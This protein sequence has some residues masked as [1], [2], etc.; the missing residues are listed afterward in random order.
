MPPSIF[1]ASE[2]E[3]TYKVQLAPTFQSQRGGKLP[4]LWLTDTADPC[5]GAAAGGHH[6][7]HSA[8]VRLM[9]RQDLAAEAYVYATA[10]ER[11]PQYCAQPGYHHNAKYGDS[12]WRGT[13][14]L[15]K[16]RWNVVRLR[17][18][19]NTPGECDGLLAVAV[20]GEECS[21]TAMCWRAG[22]CGGMVVR[23]LNFCT[24]YGGSTESFACPEDTE[25]RFKD[26]SLRRLA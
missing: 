14:K 7:S 18:R 5:S 3:L 16:G 21:C 4:G 15:A 9:W 2:V 8:S 13:L 20:N 24:F 26:F 25:A 11:S 22:E 17:V 6:C 19:V 10:A 23:A 12:L 1:P